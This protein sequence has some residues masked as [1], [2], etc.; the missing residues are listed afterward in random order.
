M[1]INDLHESS[2]DPLRKAR[3]PLDQRPVF[4]DRRRLDTVHDLNSVR[5]AHRDDTGFQRFVSDVE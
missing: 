4:A 1:S 5:V 2:I 3:M